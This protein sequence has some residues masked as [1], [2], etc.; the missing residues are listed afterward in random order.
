MAKKA[1]KGA[2][3]SKLGKKA[4]PPVLNLSN[5]AAQTIRGRH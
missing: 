1:V 2:K 3:K 5:R 4:Q